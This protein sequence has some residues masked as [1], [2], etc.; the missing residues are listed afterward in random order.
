MCS[1]CRRPF[2]SR[3]PPAICFLVPAR[4]L[5]AQ[6]NTIVYMPGACHD[7]WSKQRELPSIVALRQAEISYNGL[8]GVL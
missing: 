8:G 2:P 7:A 1:P 3:A 4:L 5:V 6:R